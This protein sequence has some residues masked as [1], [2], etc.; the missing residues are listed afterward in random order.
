M[1]P[2]GYPWLCGMKDADIKVQTLRDEDMA[3]LLENTSRGGMRLVMGGRCVKSDENESFSSSDSC[4]LYGHSLSQS[5]PYD[6]IEL[7]RG[8]PDCYMDK[9]EDIT[10]ENLYKSKLMVVL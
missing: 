3:L 9:L 6:E 5:L 10:K 4:I 1:G 8:Q 2:P 7:W